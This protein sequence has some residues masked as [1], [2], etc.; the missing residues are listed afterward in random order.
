MSEEKKET[1]EVKYL[2]SLITAVPDVDGEIKHLQF[3]VVQEVDSK[4]IRCYFDVVDPSKVK[5]A[6][7]AS[8]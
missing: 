5:L 6:E 3:T 2:T 7:D 1:I 8:V 4:K